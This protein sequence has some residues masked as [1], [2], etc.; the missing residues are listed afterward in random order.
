MC[1]SAEVS[2]TASAVLAV[3]GVVAVKKTTSKEQVLFACIPF[4]FAAQQ[5]AEGVLWLSYM[6]AGFEIYRQAATIL[7]L[8]FAQVIWPFWV[9]LSV[10]LVEKNPLRK[11]I[12]KAFLLVGITLSVYVSYCLFVYPVAGYP[13]T[14]HLKYELGFPLAH[15]LI[16]A[17]FYFVPTVLSCVVSSVKRMTTLGLI[18]FSSYILAKIFFSEY[19][20]S[21]WCF[22]SAI[23]SVTVIY[24]VHLM[25][26]VSTGSTKRS[27]HAM[28]G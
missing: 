19:A 16:A 28:E 2:F 25:R 18:I 14:H 21:V 7:F 1:F 9:P 4:V 6:R 22:F 3:S 26:P 13:D 27:T 20:L 8:V 24:V 23:I 12:I 5:L 15:S 11:N 17:V 10:L